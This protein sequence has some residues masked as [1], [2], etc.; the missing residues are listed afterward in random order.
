VTVSGEATYRRLPG[1]GRTPLG[2]D[3]LWVGEDH[4]LLVELR[5]FTESYRRFYFRDVQAITLR[6]TG[7]AGRAGILLGVLGLV[8]LGFATDA[9]PVWNVVWGS[10]SGLL[11]LALAV[12]VAL[13]SSC[14]CVLRTAL[15]TVPL[16]SLGRLRR[17]RHVIE[18]LR[19]HIELAQGTLTPE[20]ILAR[21]REEA[22]PT[23]TATAT[24]PF[25]APPP[26]AAPPVLGRDRPTRHDSGRAHEILAFVLLFSAVAIVVPVLYFHVLLS[27]ALSVVYLGRMACLVTALARQNHSDL[28]APIKTFTWT[29]FGFEIFI[30]VLGIAATA[31][32]VFKM[33]DSGA[34]TPT[35]STPPTPLAM[36]E[37]MRTN[38]LYRVSA[39][40]SSLVWLIL[41]VRGLLL[42]RRLTSTRTMPWQ[43]LSI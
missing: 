40:L 13:G 43:T 12:N 23:G 9:G 18:R 6:R 1:R 30:M 19:P 27:M 10:V 15:Q 4:L 3:S 16:R 41:G 8:F 39:F 31:G 29:T 33:L 21:V 7:R 35:A 26:V 5:G 24:L 25:T 14:S 38:S 32:V 17:A 22:G 28:P 20:A 11:F 2:S 42:H 34:L 36:M 37:L